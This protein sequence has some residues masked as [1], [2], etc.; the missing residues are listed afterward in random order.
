LARGADFFAGEDEQQRA[1]NAGI[2]EAVV[3]V[4]VFFGAVLAITGQIWL[5]VQVYHFEPTWFIAYLC[6]P[7]LCALYLAKHRR[8]ARMAGGVWIA[9]L[10]LLL[11]G[12]LIWQ[13]GESLTTAPSF[14]M[15]PAQNG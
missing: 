8:R 6:L 4:L 5:W 12:Y 11:A 7:F 10:L 1:L 9:G 3:I 2:M 13:H 14:T 15:P